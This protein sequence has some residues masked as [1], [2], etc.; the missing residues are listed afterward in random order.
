VTQVRARQRSG[1]PR[2]V[3]TAQKLRELPIDPRVAF[4]LSRIDGAST[5]ET[6]VDVTGFDADE[7][8]TILA[9]LARLGAIVL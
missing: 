9:R 1:M 3:L 8:A 5:L 4:V 6:L 2:V 7:L